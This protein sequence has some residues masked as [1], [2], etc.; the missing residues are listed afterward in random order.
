VK[1]F[2]SFITIG[3][4]G[5]SSTAFAVTNEEC[6]A[7]WKASSAYQ[8]CSPGWGTKAFGDK[9]GIYVHC[10]KPDGS[11][12]ANG[13]YSPQYNQTGKD[14]IGS[15]YSL[16]YTL[17]ELRKLNNCNGKLKVGSC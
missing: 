2:L 5:L 15:D 13:T 3:L 4:L 11:Q 10:K 1:L 9:C 16:F 14:I 12:V 8:T 17:D 7:A 6:K